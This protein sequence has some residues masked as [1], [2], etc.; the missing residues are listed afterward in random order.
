MIQHNYPTT[1]YFGCDALDSLAATLKARDTGPLMLVTDRTLVEIGLA[2][3]VVDRLAAQGI[4][5]EVFD[6]T[7]PNPIEE[8]VEKGVAFYEKHRC[9]GIIALGGGSPMD[10]AKVIK[11]A[12]KHPAPLK[13]YDDALGGDK[14]IVNSMPP[15]YAI[16]TTA[17]TGSEVGRCGVIIMR[18]SQRKTIF[19]AP[20][21]MPDIAVL[22]PTLSVGLPPHITAATGIDA[23][24]HCME[25][26]FVSDYHPMADAI[27]MAGMQL[28]REH[29]PTACVN[30]GDLGARGHMLMAA[31]MGATAFQ[32]GLGMIHSLAHP[33][34]TRYNTHHGLANALLLPDSVDWL[35]KQDLDD[36]QRRRIGDVR[37]LFPDSQSSLGDCCRS[38]FGELGIVMQLRHHDVVEDDLEILTDEAFEDICHATN[39]VPVTRDDLLEV[40][41]T[42]M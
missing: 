6:E 23:F 40:Y 24:T 38:F 25:A 39:M 30:G 14:L 20:T 22:D 15:L 17:G 35:E 37:G 27:A 28:V 32:K 7:H 16:P 42:A 1:I 3:T 5:A 4:T 33:L 8:D 19:F 2:K 11:I 12:L 18:Q 36:D 41:R 9:A 26:Y 13:Q 21:L 29:L 31:A 10:V 34:S